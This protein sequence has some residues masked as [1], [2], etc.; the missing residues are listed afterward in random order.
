M[1]RK[2]ENSNVNE[3]I[4]LVRKNNEG[5]ERHVHVITFGCQQNERDS[6]TILGLCQEMGYAKQTILRRL[7]L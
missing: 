1:I 3:Y 6:E 2:I 7:T 4:S 5:H